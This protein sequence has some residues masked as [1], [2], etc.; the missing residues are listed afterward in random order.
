MT[1]VL[2][3]AGGEPPLAAVRGM[4]AEKHTAECDLCRQVYQCQHEESH[5]KSGAHRCALCS[6]RGT[7]YDYSQRRYFCLDCDAPSHLDVTTIVHKRGCK[8]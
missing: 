4:I 6:P 1:S 3:N 5:S 7:R 2:F 8:R